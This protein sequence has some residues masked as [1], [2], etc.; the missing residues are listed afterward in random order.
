MYSKTAVGSIRI[1]DRPMKML[2]Y[3]SSPVQLY[4]VFCIHTCTYT[5]HIRLG[6]KKWALKTQRVFI[7]IEG[8]SNSMHIRIGECKEGAPG[9]HLHGNNS[10]WKLWRSGD[11]TTWK[12]I[13]LSMSKHE[14]ALPS[15]NILIID[16]SYSICNMHRFPKSLMRLI[17]TFASYWEQCSEIRKSILKRDQT[18]NE[19]IN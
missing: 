15:V 16:V 1:Q 18:N 19:A 14:W 8:Y 11:G 6:V 13:I 3:S 4:S 2:L 7:R 12:Y 10:W 9:I 17:I 5:V